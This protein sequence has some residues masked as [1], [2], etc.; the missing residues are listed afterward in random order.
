MLV[1]SIKLILPKCKYN[2]NNFKNSRIKKK[3]KSALTSLIC[4]EVALQLLSCLVAAS[5]PL[6]QG[7]GN[8]LQ[9]EI[10]FP[11]RLPAL[12][13]SPLS[14]RYVFLSSLPGR[15]N[16]LRCYISLYQISSKKGKNVF[17]LFALK[18][19][20]ELFVWLSL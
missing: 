1:R 14:W 2:K 9:K 13:L 10:T 19:D 8:F 7:I 18:V 5:I 17:G 15:Y 11:K 16:D 3:K 6:A 4:L 12:F 20:S